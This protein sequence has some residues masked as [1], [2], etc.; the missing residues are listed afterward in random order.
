MSDKENISDSASEQEHE[1]FATFNR[2]DALARSVV[3]VYAVG[4]RDGEKSG[5]KRGLSQ[6]RQEFPKWWY[7]LF[8]ILPFIM[9]FLG[10]WLGHNIQ[11]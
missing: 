2:N 1:L 5:Y 3:G 9:F 7:G 4:F 6:G 8:L 10:F 11:F